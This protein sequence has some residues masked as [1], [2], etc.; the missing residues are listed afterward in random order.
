MIFTTI[1]GQLAGSTANAPLNLFVSNDV[2]S[3]ETKL[4]KSRDDGG[5]ATP[6]PIP[7]TAVKSSSA[8]STWW[9]TAWE[10]RTLRDFT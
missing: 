6:V 5:R 4:N 1:D 9:V 2:L 8:E 7:N 3:S 10:D